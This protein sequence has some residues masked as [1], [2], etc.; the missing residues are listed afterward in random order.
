[1]TRY[2][3]AH[4]AHAC[5]QT[6]NLQSTNRDNHL[7]PERNAEKSPGDVP[8]ADAPEELVSEPLLA[9]WMGKES[10]VL[11]F[12]SNVHSSLVFPV[13]ALDA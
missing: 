3:N 8:D 11:G 13:H 2:P 12:R 10:T 9:A 4:A 5:V 1:M 6:V 7:E